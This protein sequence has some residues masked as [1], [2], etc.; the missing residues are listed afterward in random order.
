MP[1]PYR[2]PVAHRKVEFSEKELNAILAHNTGLA[3]KMAID[4]SDNLLSLRLLIPLDDEMPFFGGK[5][6]K[7]TAGLALSYAGG[8]PLI[9]VKGLSVWGVP[10]PNAYMG[11]IKNLDIVKEF[12]ESKFW[13]TISTGI[14]DIKVSEGNMQILL[15]Q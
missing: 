13:R 1:E 12:D 5:T 2:E 8:N 6:L 7:V 11:G 15:K 9:I 14:N 10:V 4:L 3:H